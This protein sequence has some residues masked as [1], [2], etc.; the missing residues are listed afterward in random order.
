MQDFLTHD[1]DILNQAQIITNQQNYKKYLPQDNFEEVIDEDELEEESVN[2]KE[3]P[4]VQ[5][6]E[7]KLD[8]NLIKQIRY[9]NSNPKYKD[10]YQF[11]IGEKIYNSKVEVMEHHTKES[12][13]LGQIF[14]H[15]KMNQKSHRAYFMQTYNLKKGIE[16]FGTRGKNAA[17]K[18]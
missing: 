9:K 6:C 17:K 3:D 15:H 5:H 2:L 1:Y 11:F 4:E 18:K 10:F 12:Q 7:S 14:L 16:K 13:A 8:T